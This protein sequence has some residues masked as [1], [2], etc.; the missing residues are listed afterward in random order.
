MFSARFIPGGTHEQAQYFS[1]LQ[2]KTTSP[3]CAARYFDA[4]GDLDV[5]D[6]LSEVKATDACNARV[7]DRIVPFEFGRQL[8][9]GIPHARFI[10]LP[11]RG[12]ICSRSMSR[13]PAA[14]SKRS[15]FS[16]RG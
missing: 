3:E 13:L 12:T 4:V 14:S 10:A 1:E 9:A 15:T 8:S 16:Q 2:L 6:L 11:G 7:D 5:T